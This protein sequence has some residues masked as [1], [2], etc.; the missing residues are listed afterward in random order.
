MTD[1]EELE[2]RYYH[3]AVEEWH[4]ELEQDFPFLGN[5]HAVG[6]SQNE[7][8]LLR[9]LGR[10]EALKIVHAITRYFHAEAVVALGDSASLED[11]RIVH[12]FAGLRGGERQRNDRIRR[13]RGE[14]TLPKRVKGLKPAVRAAVVPVL[15]TDSFRPDPLT[16]CYRTT[17]GRWTILT[18]VEAHK[19]LRYHHDICLAGHEM[20]AWQRA[21]HWW[22]AL[23]WMGLSSTT[24]WWLY[25]EEDIPAATSGLVLACQRFLEAAPK[26]LPK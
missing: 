11:E 3:W 24:K 7:V 12:H 20:P 2:I 6:A 19:E 21:R 8:A 23:S 13:S 26:L 18:H 5:L 4:R 9:R 25:G 15:G 16:T 22:S 10:E 1:I 17:I 14:S